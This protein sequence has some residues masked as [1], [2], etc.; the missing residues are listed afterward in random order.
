MIAVGA[1]SAAASRF[2]DWVLCQIGSANSSPLAIVAALGRAWARCVIACFP[3]S[4]AL[5]VCRDVL[6]PS[7]GF[8]GEVGDL[9]RLLSWG[10]AT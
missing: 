6:S 1:R 4:L 7:R 8:F 5:G 3:R 10:K 9:S 2:A